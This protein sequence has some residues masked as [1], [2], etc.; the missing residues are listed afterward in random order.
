M[1]LRQD[2]VHRGLVTAAMLAEKCQHIRINAQA[3]L[4]LGPRPDDRVFEEIRALLRNVGKIDIFISPPI[5][6]RPIHFG[7]PFRIPC[8]LPMP[9]FGAR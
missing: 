8:A 1:Y 7:L 9:P 6:S 2:S 4:L 5:N 3:N